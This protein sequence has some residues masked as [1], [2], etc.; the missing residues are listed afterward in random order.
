MKN[1]QFAVKIR[2]RNGTV[3]TELIEATNVFNVMEKFEEENLDYIVCVRI[4]QLGLNVI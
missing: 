3:T 1:K 4:E 2:W